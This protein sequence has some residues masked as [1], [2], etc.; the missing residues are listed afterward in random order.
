MAPWPKSMPAQT[1]PRVCAVA[2]DRVRVAQSVH[3][4]KWLLGRRWFWTSWRGLAPPSPSELSGSWPAILSAKL[5]LHAHLR[6]VVP[7]WPELHAFFLLLPASASTAPS[8]SRAAD[9]SPSW[10][11]PSLSFC[12]WGRFLRHLLRLRSRT[13][14]RHGCL[15]REAQAGVDCGHGCCEWSQA[16]RYVQYWCPP[17]RPPSVSL[18]PLT[19]QTGKCA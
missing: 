15:G 6:L 11:V 2:A 14:L 3:P 13:L 12:D 10:Q 8:S 5:S 17:E 9:A 19:L 7:F 16:L 4:W 18:L 1:S